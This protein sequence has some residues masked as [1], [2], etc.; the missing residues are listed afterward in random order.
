MREQ[1]KKKPIYPKINNMLC[2]EKN[3]VVDVWFWNNG[4]ENGEGGDPSEMARER[5]RRKLQNIYLIP[6]RSKTRN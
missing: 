5:K 3:N 6:L 2:V 4:K 1:Q